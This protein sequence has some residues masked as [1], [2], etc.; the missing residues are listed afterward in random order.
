MAIS[1]SSIDPG[2]AGRPLTPTRPRRYMR[3]GYN[4]AMQPAATITVVLMGVTGSGKSS[5]M[6]ALIERFPAVTGEGD[7]FHPAA[8]IEKMRAGLPLNDEDRGPWLDALAAWIGEQE[9]A[10]RDAV[11]TCSALKRSYRDRLRDGHPSVWFAHL[12]ASPAV[13]RQRVEFRRGHF[14]PSSLLDS[15]L[16]TLEALGPDEP[17]ATFPTKETPSQIAEAIVARLLEV[18]G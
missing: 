17:G 18:R 9:A 2:R 8:N 16:R 11:V 13:L 1:G 3:L 6:S 10:M 7:D 5:V 14:M 4:S 12:V 15:Q